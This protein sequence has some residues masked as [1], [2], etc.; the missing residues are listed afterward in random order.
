[1]SP[2]MRSA[3]CSFA[4]A[5]RSPAPPLPHRLAFAKPV[6]VL[7]LHIVSRSS[8]RQRLGP[9]QTPLCTDSRSY[10][11][12][13]FKIIDVT[14]KIIALFSIESTRVVSPTVQRFARSDGECTF[15]SQRCRP[16]ARL[17]D[18]A[19]QPDVSVTVIRSTTRR[20]VK[21]SHMSHA[22]AVSISTFVCLPQR[23]R[24]EDQR[25][26]SNSIPPNTLKLQL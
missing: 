8:C 22:N 26:H 4:T 12:R 16:K 19:R 21:E 3:E 24:L 6:D 9:I 13:A 18:N 25:C 10:G 20:F 7:H 23:L 14:V 5:R 15:L 1:M 17:F 11:R 2:W